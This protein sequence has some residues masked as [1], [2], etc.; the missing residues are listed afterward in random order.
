MCLACSIMNRRGPSVGRRGLL[1]ASAVLA[2]T[3]LLTEALP[4]FGPAQAATP[5][6][7]VVISAGNLWDGLA[8]APQGPA[9]LLVVNGRIAAIGPSVGRPPGAQV[10]TLPGHTV[11]PG[12]IDTHVHVTLRPEL[13]D[14]IFSL[15]SSAKALLGVQA[16]GILLD[17]GFTTV[18]DTGDMDVHGY[19]TSDLAQALAQGRIV[20]PRLIPSGHLLSPRG[21]HGDGTPLLGADSNPWQNSLADGV[22]E[23]RRVVRTEISRGAQWVKYAGSGGFSSPADDPSQV[24]YSQEEMNVMVGAARDLGVPATLH[25]YGDEGIRRALTA[26]VRGIEHG[27]L[28]SRETLQTIEDKGVYLVPTQFAVIRQA[29]LIDDDAFWSA[30]A[31]PAYVRRKY[32]RYAAALMEAAANMAASKVKI[33]FGSDIGTYSFATNNAGEFGELVANGLSP[34]RA[35]KAATSMAAE[36]LQQPD[37]GTLMVGK[38]ADIVAMPGNP[39]ERIAV[40]EQVDFVMHDGVIRKQPGRG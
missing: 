18:R 7:A 17:H 2:A 15:S 31:K 27:N 16:L 20:G 8:N 35:L 11:T 36:M 21:G 32:R 30:A 34:V 13:E 9:E 40:T 24:L 3:P 28:A 1:H 6:P 25:V 33:V 19:T 37:I 14:K 23:I 12:F 29:R 22:E 26:G 39:F 4:R 5:A 38:T 10:V